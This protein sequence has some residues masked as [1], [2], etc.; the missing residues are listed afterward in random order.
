MKRM[1]YFI[2]F[3]ILVFLLISV[4]AKKPD[5]GW[6]PPGLDE[7]KEQEVDET[8]TI[9]Y[10]GGGGIQ[11]VVG[12][13]PRSPEFFGTT[14]RG[15][16]L[17]LTQVY[18]AGKPSDDAKVVA[19]SDLFGTLNFPLLKHLEDGFYGLNITIN[20]NITKGKYKL[21]YKA[22]QASQYDEFTIL[23]NVDPGL[24]MDISLNEEYSKGQNLEIS[25]FIYDFNKTLQSNVNTTI[26]AYQEGLIFRNELF[27]D[28]KGFFRY[29]FPIS[30]AEPE[31]KWIIN[32]T[33]EDEFGNFG[34]KTFAP[35]IKTPK[36]IVYYTVS[37][38]NPL[39]GN[40]YKRGEIIPITVE[41]K[42]GINLLADA[43]VS[44]KT[45]KG[46]EIKLRS[47]E[48][49]IY[50]ASYNLN[51]ND[52]LGTR[53]I[54]VEAE[55]TIGGIVKVGGFSI[56]IEIEPTDIMLELI[57]PENNNFYS[58]SKIKFF[59]K[60][61]YFDGSPVRGADVK[62]RLSNNAVVDLIEKKEGVYIGEY[63]IPENYDGSLS[64]EL[65]AED[66]YMNEGSS[67][68]QV[69]YVTKR[70]R[71]ELFLLKI[72]RN[73][74]RPYWWAIAI[75]IIILSLIYRPYYEIRS[76]SKKLQRLKEEEKNIKNMQID[77]ENKYYKEGSISKQEFNQLM[78]E[79]EERLSKNKEM[80]N[81]LKEKLKKQSTKNNKKNKKIY[82]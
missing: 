10:S 79:Y 67:E 78:V 43:N 73:Y 12:I 33:A 45:I 30:F 19:E 21:V 60:A 69:L 28:K 75:F 76:M 27:T 49:G 11:K 41:V 2:I 8:T 1:R 6:I 32:I 64:F 37:F 15:T 71:F 17:F 47:I 56:P 57:N 26:S 5:Q 18:Y 54:S 50:S 9:E 24:R 42:D 68:P 81:E 23:I 62:T 25:G 61:K 40:T 39:K 74:V 52:P 80:I 29:I 70:G 16:Y 82:P 7:G 44:M 3:L 38:L 36:G 77:T 66:S 14:K 22:E 35:K 31:G 13:I 34:Y 51:F 59:V 48:P 72:Y 46:N 53:K 65:F 58:A 20:K 4:V 63:S 55:K